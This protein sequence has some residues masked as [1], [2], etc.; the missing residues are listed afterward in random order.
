MYFLNLRCLS[1]YNVVTKQ[2]NSNFMAAKKIITTITNLP[3]TV[4]RFIKEVRDEL[5]KVSWPDRQTTLNYTIVV[6]VSSIVIGVVTGGIDLAL[7]RLIEL[8]II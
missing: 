3:G 6:V 5:K 2:A 4:F 7:S 1:D 8:L